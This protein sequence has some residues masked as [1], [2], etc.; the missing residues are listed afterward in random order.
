M[1]LLIVLLLLLALSA[2]SSE[3]TAVTPGQYS[4]LLTWQASVEME[5]PIVG[6]NV[7]RSTLSGGPYSKLTSNTVNALEFSD[8][9]VS[10]GTTYYYVVTAVD[11][12][13]V[14]SGFSNQISAITPEG[15]N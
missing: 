6:Y 3:S 1:R 13:G 12:Q 2:C 11:S 15:Q 9:A 5:N 7:Y 14:E 10:D 8:T 4:V